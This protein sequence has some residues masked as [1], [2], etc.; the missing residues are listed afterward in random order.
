MPI[1][2][3]N[4]LRQ[5]YRLEG[6]GDR[7]TLIL[8]NSLGT[9]LGMWDKQMLRLNEAFRVLR[10]DT[11]GHGA[12]EVTDGDYTVELLARDVL[13][14]ADALGIERF[15]FCGLS[16]G[17]LTGQWLG[18]YAASRLT[19]LA[20]CNAAPHLP[21]PE[22]WSARMDTARQ[23]GMRALVDPVMQRFFSEP[24]RARDEAFFHTVRRTFLSTDPRGYASCCAAIRD[25]DFRAPLGTI[26]TPTLAIGGTLDAATPPT[27]SSE[28]LARTIPGARLVNLEAG[29][30]SNVEQ[31]EA[32]TDALL[33]FVTAR[34]GAA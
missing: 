32:F 28:L 13:A 7:P 10:Y 12:S 21:P 26:E 22:G 9:D 3:A 33:G 23:Q 31:P 8:S 15:A 25:A 30:I 27:I 17:G 14:L 18:I 1:C 4:G 16:L 34:A 6:R 2:K 11:R 5:A 24:Y 19:H 29:H 20:L